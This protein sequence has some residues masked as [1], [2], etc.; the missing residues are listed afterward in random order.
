MPHRLPLLLLALAALAACGRPPVEDDP[1][2]TS[3]T[4]IVLDGDTSDPI[5]N[6]LIQTEPFVK[7]VLTNTEGRYSIDESLVIGGSYRVSGSKNGYVTNSVEIASIV[8]GANSVADLVLNPEGPEL[9]VSTTTVQIN[10]GDD[11]ATFQLSNSGDTSQPLT[12]SVTSVNSWITD[13]TPDS[14]SV[15]STP[16]TVRVDIDRATLPAGAGDVLGSLEVTTNGGS[17]TVAVR[18]IR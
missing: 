2:I 3:I 5:A 1:I 16:V 6:V 18:V 9:T 14:G 15:L 7:Q 10:S 8:E 12:Y 11:A 13:I 4:G 17:Q